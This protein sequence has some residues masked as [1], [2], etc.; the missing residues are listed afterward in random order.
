MKGYSE[1]V[2]DQGRSPYIEGFAVTSEH[3]QSAASLHLIQSLFS[4]WKNYMIV[5][6]P[7]FSRK[8]YS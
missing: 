7:S 2:R 8:T 5:G 6:T 1:L 3:D 4:M